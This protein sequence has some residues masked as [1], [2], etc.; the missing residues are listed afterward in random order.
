VLDTEQLKA[1]R[2]KRHFKG[3][4]DE[5]KKYKAEKDVSCLQVNKTTKMGNRK[6]KFR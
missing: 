1:F 3:R 2:K 5:D 6:G 4:V